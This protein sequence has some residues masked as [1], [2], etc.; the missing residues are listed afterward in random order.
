MQRFL[1]TVPGKTTLFLATILSLCL[2]ASCILGVFAMA[3]LDF[4]TTPREEVQNNYLRQAVRSDA[5]DLVNSAAWH[6]QMEPDS[7]YIPKQDTLLRYVILNEDGEEVVRAGAPQGDVADYPFRYHYGINASNGAT[8]YFGDGTLE[9]EP[10]SEGFQAEL[11]EN[12][13]KWYTFCGYL[14]EDVIASG[15]Y[16]QWSRLVDFAYSNRYSVIVLGVVFG[17]LSIF[18]FV[19]LM[20]VSGRRPEVETLVPGPMNWIP[21]DLIVLGGIGILGCGAVAVSNTYYY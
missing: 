11:R 12:D 6:D 4:Y 19:A 15:S 3:G 7:R 9:G 1:R 10:L 14:D 13:M 16:D 18:G 2:A 21:S 20:C 17:V 5:Y 8:S